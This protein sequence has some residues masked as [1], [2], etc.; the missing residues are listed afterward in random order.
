MST[1][2]GKYPTLTAS[3]IYLAAHNNSG[4]KVGDYVKVVSKAETHES[5]WLNSWEKEMDRAIGKVF[6]ISSCGETSGFYLSG[7]GCS[8]PWF[9]LQKATRDEIEQMMMEE[10]EEKGFVIGATVENERDAYSIKGKIKQILFY[11]PGDKE[12]SGSTT[13]E[14]RIAL[15]QPFVWVRYHTCYAS[16]IDELVVMDVTKKVKTQEVKPLKKTVKQFVFQVIED[17]MGNKI[18]LINGQTI[19]DSSQFEFLEDYAK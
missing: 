15:G 9:V 7:T 16:P 12:I 5:G 8:F 10:A 13:V 2:I 11:F 1:P 17:E 19:E 6:R 4:F 3:E 18:Y 14:E